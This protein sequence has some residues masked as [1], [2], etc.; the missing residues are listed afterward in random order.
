ML[1]LAS[2]GAKVLQIRSVEIAMK[3]KVPLWVKSSF[4]A[5]PGTLVCEE[6]KAMEDILVSGVALDRTEAKLSIRDVPDAPGVAAKIFGALDDKAISVDLI[7]QNP[8][9][10]GKT[11]LTF[12]VARADLLKTRDV[13]KKVVKSLKAGAVDVDDAVCKVSIVGVGMRT[14]SGVAARMFKTLSKE[15]INILAISTSEI[16]VSCLIA[17]RYGELAV[18]AL[19]SEFGLDAT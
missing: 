5:D 18:R 16:R 19:H 2:L 13:I 11:Q 6:D 7:V 10:N 4:S 17:T 3:F 1:E 14:H 15:G 8:P 12:T 9:I